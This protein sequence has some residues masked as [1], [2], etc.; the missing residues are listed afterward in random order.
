MPKQMSEKQ[1]IANRNNARK[2]TGPRTPEG[3]AAIA[4]NHVTHGL[5]ARSLILRDDPA[6]SPEQFAAL[7]AGLREHLRPVGRLEELVIDRIA[8]CHW[9]L[10]RAYR[11]ELRATLD[12]RLHLAAQ[13]EHA[14]QQPARAKRPLNT[15]AN[16]GSSAEEDPDTDACCL[17]DQQDLERLVRYEGLVDRELHR[18]MTQLHRLQTLRCQIA[19]AQARARREQ[20][21]DEDDY[22]AEP[23]Q[24]ANLLQQFK[25]IPP[26]LTGLPVPTT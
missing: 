12:F 16:Q 7:V 2:S 17:P 23:T 20:E 3:K 15:H 14:E 11:F 6:E 18:A 26:G 22:G 8:A 24:L 4:Q 21:D 25:A 5:C 1:R 9:R 10:R 13:Q 19:L